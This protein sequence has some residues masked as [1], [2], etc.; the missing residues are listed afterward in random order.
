MAKEEDE[1]ELVLGLRQIA[2]AED[3]FCSSS[4]SEA[5]VIW[6]IEIAVE[7]ILS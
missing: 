1:A 7:L 4:S 2:Q 6:R 3:Y 5:G